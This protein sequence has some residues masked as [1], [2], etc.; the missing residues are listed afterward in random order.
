MHICTYVCMYDVPIVKILMSISQ[1]Y[2]LQCVDQH[3]T[4]LTKHAMHTTESTT[5]G[6][7]TYKYTTKDCTYSTNY[8]VKSVSI[9]IL[10]TVTAHC[11]E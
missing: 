9:M 8:V 1:Q 2:T 5:K 3:Y 10:T 6:Y 11:S 7:Y 4:E